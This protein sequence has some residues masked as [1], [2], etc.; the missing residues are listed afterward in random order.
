MSGLVGLA[1]TDGQRS[2]GLGCV[3]NIFQAAILIS[4]VLLILRFLVA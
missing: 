2:A 3:R 1:I 4:G